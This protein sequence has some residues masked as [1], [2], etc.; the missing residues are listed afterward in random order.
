MPRLTL[1]ALA[2][3]AAAPLPAGGQAPPPPVVFARRA[4]R[5]AAVAA[6]QDDESAVRAAGLK[7]DDPAGLVGY[8]RKRTLSDAD[9]ARIRAVIRR[10]GDERF[11]ER[12]KA[13]EEAETFGVAAI[14][15]LRAAAQSD[16]DPEVAFRTGETLKRIETVPHATVA[17]AAA[18][19][20]AKGNPPGAAAALLGFLPSADSPAVEDEVRTALAAVAVRDGKVDPAVP[21]ALTDALPVR[22]AAA[23]VA[24]VTAGA[25]ANSPAAT[26]KPLVV[27]AYKAEAD[28]DA[29]FRMGFALAT[30]GRDPEAIA[31]LIDSLPDLAAARGRLWLAEDVLLQVAGSAAPKARLGPDRAGLEKAREAWK[32]WWDGRKGSIDPAAFRYQPRTTGELVLF[33]MENPQ[34]NY[35]QPGRLTQLAADGKPAWK[36]NGVM[37]PADVQVTADGRIWV[38]EQNWHRITERDR[39][40]RILQTWQANQGQPMGFQ[41]LDSGTVLVAYQHLVVEHDPKAGWKE[42]NKFARGGND[43][44]AVYRGRTGPTYVLTQNGN[45]GTILRLDEKWRELP[46]PQRTGPL[47][48]TPKI[49]GVDADRVLVTE[50]S[51]V[52]EY[53]FSKEEQKSGEGAWWVAASNPSSA[54]RLANGNTL[55]ADLGVPLKE[56]GPD[57]ETVWSYSP[58]EN[59]RVIRAERR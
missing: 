1:L 4:V 18:R 34:N 51:R 54:Q 16:P 45:Q 28:A 26:T 43:I 13:S 29:R 47:A 22:R 35:G 37:P 19:L 14:G 17:A 33:M 24:L 23:G 58:A 11:E 46:K 42:V 38:L 8:F 7:A 27:A 20:L 50:A 12:L 59:L 57:K 10:M 32:A 40:G 44:R 2:A 31:G 55:V 5:P 21:A 48:P 53:D 25:A 39:Q 49:D 6:A 15:P 56:I 3:A 30:L 41:P 9:L 52:V 36:V